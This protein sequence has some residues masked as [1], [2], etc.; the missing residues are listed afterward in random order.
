MPIYEYRCGACAHRF[1]A[2]LQ[3]RDE[4]APECPKCGA[5]QSE[6]MLSAFAVTRGGP[7]APPAR[8]GSADCAC[9]R[10]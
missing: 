2:L 3:R 8:C 4:A 10:H 7:P 5:S 9:R 1:E 6:K